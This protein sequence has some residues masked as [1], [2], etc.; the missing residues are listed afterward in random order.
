MNDC[1]LRAGQ[2]AIIRHSLMV[3]EGSRAAQP[4]VPLARKTFL[5]TEW[6]N[7]KFDP[8]WRLTRGIRQ[9]EDGPHRRCMF[10]LLA[11]IFRYV[12]AEWGIVPAFAPV[13]WTGKVFFLKLL[14]GA[15]AVWRIT[16]KMGARLCYRLDLLLE[17]YN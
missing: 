7:D 13:L 3:P 10:F 17:S 6:I 14:F 8:V 12:G 2:T 4:P 16:N 1:R 9:V 11:T 5:E 15:I